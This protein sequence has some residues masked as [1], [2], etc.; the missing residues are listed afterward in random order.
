MYLLRASSGYRNDSDIG[1]GG[2]VVGWGPSIQLYYE[3]LAA[4]DAAAAAADGYSYTLEG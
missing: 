1:G 3:T 2:G 4:A